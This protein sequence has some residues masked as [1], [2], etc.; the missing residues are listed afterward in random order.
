M[1]R[2]AKRI[3]VVGGG[4]SGLSTAIALARNGVQ[5][6]LFEARDA[7]VERLARHQPLDIAVRRVVTPM[8]HARR[9]HLYRGALYGLSPAATPAQQFP[10]RTPVQ[11]L[12]LAGQTTYPGFGV[13]TSLFSGIFAAEAVLQHG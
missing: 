2:Q 7:A 13:A 5:V 3:A 9:M 11:G 8:D 6:D 4:L 12:Y 10:H 1:T